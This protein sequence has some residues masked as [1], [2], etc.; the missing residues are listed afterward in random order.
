MTPK[1]FKK[2]AKR[3]LKLYNVLSNCKCDHHRCMHVHDFEDAV[4]DI[5]E[6]LEAVLPMLEQE[7][8][9]WR[10]VPEE[11]THSKA[12]AN[13]WLKFGLVVE[14]LYTRPLLKKRKT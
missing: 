14:P 12:R 5:P 10:T 8:V 3:F 2:K 1:Q 13:A 6:L 7:P 11:I 4:W 9:A